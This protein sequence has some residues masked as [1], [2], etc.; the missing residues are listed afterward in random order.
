VLQAIDF[1]ITGLEQNRLITRKSHVQ[2]LSPRPI[3]QGLPTAGPI[4]F[5]SVIQ[6]T[7]QFQVAGVLDSTPLLR[8]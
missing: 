6:P 8:I 7:I 3:S 1:K 2:T 5:W 4:H